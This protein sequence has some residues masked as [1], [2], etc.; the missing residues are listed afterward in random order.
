MRREEIIQQAE[1][2]M[3]GMMGLHLNDAVAILSIATYYIASAPDQSK[4]LVDKSCFGFNPNLRRMRPGGIS[5]IDKD[6]EV[7]AYIHGLGRPYLSIQAIHKVL[8]KQFGKERTPSESSLGRYLQK[9]TVASAPD[10]GEE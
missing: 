7:R 6:P 1:I 9:I 5:L 2:I 3:N 8:I 10:Q 4:D